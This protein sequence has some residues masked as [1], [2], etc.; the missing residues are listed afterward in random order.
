MSEPVV[1]E[2]FDPKA[3]EMALD[4][5][6]KQAIEIERMQQMLEARS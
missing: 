4:V 1:I 3:Q 6:V 5:N 2:A